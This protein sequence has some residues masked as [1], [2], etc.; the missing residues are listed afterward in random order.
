MGANFGYILV[1]M[2]GLD[3]VIHVAPYL[4]CLKLMEHRRRVDGRVKPGHDD[5]LR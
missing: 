2:T 5:G 4:K 3:P 1:V